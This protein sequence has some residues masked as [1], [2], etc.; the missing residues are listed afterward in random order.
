MGSELMG[1]FKDAYEN[2]YSVITRAIA[3]IKKI[4]AFFKGEPEEETVENAEE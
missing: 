3:F 2:A 1:L 4:F